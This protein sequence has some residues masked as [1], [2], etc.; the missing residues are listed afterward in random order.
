MAG[1]QW[2]VTAS[3]Q[4]LTVTSAGREAF[5]LRKALDAPFRA[6]AESAWEKTPGCCADHDFEAV[7]L[8]GS[9]LGFRDRFYGNCP[10]TAHP[11]NAS[12]LGTIDLAASGG[13]GF[14]SDGEDA[15]RADE[16]T[17]KLVSLAALY[18]AKV[19]LA[20][21]QKDPLLAKQVGGAGTLEKLQEAIAEQGVPVKGN[22]CRFRLSQDFLTRFVFHH[23]EGNK[24]AVRVSLEPVGG[25]CSNAT[26]DL[27]LLMD[28]P[29]KMPAAARALVRPKAGEKVRAKIS[30]CTGKG[31]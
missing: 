26:A 18:D 4:D 25:A 28:W 7:S 12:R 13:L 19:L 21:F 14:G 22:P 2:R 11:T 10:N 24:V 5:S 20:A 27:G 6:Y 31:E 17:G 23:A 1:P 3:K 30:Y 8:A 29:A 16:Q 15:T 9:Y